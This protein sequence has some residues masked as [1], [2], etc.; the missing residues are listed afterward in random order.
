MPEGPTMASTP[1]RVRAAARPVEHRRP[2]ASGGGCASSRFL[3]G[4]NYALL[5]LRTRDAMMP[6]LA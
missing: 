1:P 5:T 4:K 6:R 2:H 3:G